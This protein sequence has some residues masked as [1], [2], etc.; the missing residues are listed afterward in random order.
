MAFIP[1]QG[2]ASI[3]CGNLTCM[4]GELCCGS[5]VNMQVMTMCAASCPDGGLTI[6]CDGPESCGG[7]PCCAAVANGA[8][9]NVS[10]T[11]APTDC[12]PSID[13]MTQAGQDRLCHVDADCG[14]GKPGISAFGVTLPLNQCCTI[15]SNG[16]STHICL[17][18]TAI[19]LGM[20]FGL[21]ITGTC[22]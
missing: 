12:A 18:A 19:T 10:C 16:Q 5:F 6:A 21:G 20:M 17:N 9:Q 22:P 3:A 2:D 7:N 1:P 13:V 8:P 15:T 14:D 4:P 11:A